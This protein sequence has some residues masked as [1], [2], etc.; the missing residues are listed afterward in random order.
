MVEGDVFNSKLYLISPESDVFPIYPTPES[1]CWIIKSMKGE[2]VIIT[3]IDA[4]S[5]SLLGYGIP[6]PYTGFSLSGPRAQYPCSGS[7][8]EWYQSAE[9]WFSIMGYPTNSVKWPT[10]SEIKNQIQDYQVVL[11]YELAHGASTA[12]AS[13]CEN[14]KYQYTTAKDIESW[15]A[16]YTSKSF[17]FLGSCKAMCDVS[18][19]TLSYEFRKGSSFNTVTIGYCGIDCETCENCWANS[20]NWQ[21]QMFSYMC[22]GYTIKGAFDLSLADYPMCQDCVRFAGDV[23]FT[24]ET[25]LYTPL[26][27]SVKK[28][29]DRSLLLR[30]YINILTW[31]P[32]ELN[33]SIDSYRIYQVENGIWNLV[34]E[35][36]PDVYEYWHR[37]VTGSKKYSY[38]LVSVCCGKESPPAYFEVK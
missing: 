26:D 5:G 14:G 36:A 27:F 31:E 37:D 24:L 23:D 28:V 20:V 4:M 11:F 17:V 32:N 7:W 15:M 16:S 6:P 8:D 30:E 35:L 13:G 18:N 25:F 34:I 38:V 33:Y 29:E 12:F 19:D 10:E 1:P 2:N 9:E 22:E 3:I 21:E